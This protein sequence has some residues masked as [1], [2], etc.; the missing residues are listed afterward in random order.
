[1]TRQ[2][3]RFQSILVLIGAALLLGLQPAPGQ[4]VDKVHV[5]WIGNSLVYYNDLP[6]MVA[7]L[8]QAGGQRPIVYHQE[9]PGGCT[10][11][12]HWND[13][14]AMAKLRSRTWDFVVLQEHSQKPLKEAEPT[15]EYAKKFD[16]EIQKQG[17][18]TLL[19]LPFPLA[20]APENQDK[21][22]KLHEDLATK[23]GAPVV[24]VGPAWAKVQ[25]GNA[26][27][28]LFN[29][30]GVHPNRTGSYLAACAF[31]AAIYGKSPEGLPGKIG[32][33]SDQEARPL[34]AIAWQV[35]KE[36]SARGQAAVVG[37]SQGPAA[38]D[39]FLLKTV[40]ANG[41]NTMTLTVTERV[42]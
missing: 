13:G 26:P 38:A 8:A 34:Q 21:L 19:Y 1:M 5:L 37:A 6:K 9:T 23:L 35:V 7:E 16:T 2:G 33:L 36:R 20:R 25:A 27:P 42:R 15:F 30:D 22:T 12:K 40:W 3:F 4:D 39:P 11:E 24:P 41:D 28:N 18:K 32:G 17:G 31:Y 10:L 14:K 29:N